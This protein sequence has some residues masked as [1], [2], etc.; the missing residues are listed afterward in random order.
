MAKNILFRNILGEFV[1]DPQLQITKKDK[2]HVREP[3]DKELLPI[4]E[5][6]RKE[7][8]LKQF[9]E[10]NISITKKKIK[11]SFSKDS[12]LIQSSNSIE[13][14]TRTINTHV[15]RLREWT[16]LSMPEKSRR[17]TDNKIFV[18]EIAKTE[19]P[20]EKDTMSIRPQQVHLEQLR[21]FARMIKKMYDEKETME[22]YLEKGMEQLCPNLSYVA[23]PTIG[24]RLLSYAGSLKRLA[25][26]P[27]SKIQLLG[28]ESALFRHLKT[29]A[30]GPKHG[31]IHEHPKVQ[32]AGNK[33]K[34]ARRLADKI[35]I[36][37]RVDYFKGEFYGDKLV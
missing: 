32:Q 5:K 12:S 29:G 27:A 26:S 33:G 35:S 36:A 20:E 24:A 14:I 15:K 18:E 37:S 25:I 10:K 8:Y 28:A 21:S 3:E 9:R 23:G 16:S 17:L 1:L 31:L 34:A 11:E 13:E 22:K 4:L 2:K 7:E 19:G 6:F 30:R